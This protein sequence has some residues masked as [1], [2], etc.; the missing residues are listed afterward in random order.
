MKKLIGLSLAFVS[1]LSSQQV[2]LDE[3]KIY[4]LRNDNIKIS[5]SN[6]G[7]VLSIENFLSLENYDFLTDQFELQTDQGAISNSED[8]PIRIIENEKSLTYIFDYGKLDLE[9]LYTLSP[10][11]AFFRRSLRV[12][13]KTSLRLKNLKF[14]KSIFS[15]PANYSS[16]LITR[17][18][19]QLI[20]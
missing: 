14:G 11:N 4:S 12:V 10:D 16:K 13:A 3:S 2:Q 1:F 9:L 19:S 6:T 18:S 8:L 17:Y 20:F 7:K 5:I 15:Q